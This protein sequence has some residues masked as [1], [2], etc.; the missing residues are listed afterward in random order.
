MTRSWTFARGGLACLL[1][2]LA[3]TCGGDNPS[4]PS[5]TP[6]GPPASSVT[7][8]TISGDASLTSPSETSQLT[9]TAALADGS[10][11]DVTALS[12]WN[13]SD[14]SI[15]TMSGTGLMTAVAL[16]TAVVEANYRGHTDLLDARVMPDG[17]FILSGS[18][19]EPVDLPIS[20]ALVEVIGGGTVGPRATV[21]EFGSYRFV[22]VSGT[23]SV[24]ASRSGYRSEEQSVTM[25]KDR[26]VN[27]ELQP[28]T[29]PAQMAGTYELTLTASSSCSA[30]LPR[31]ARSR[32][33][34][35]RIEQSGATVEVSLS[36]ADFVDTNGYYC[37][38]GPADHFTGVV[39]GNKAFFDLN[40]GGGFYSRDCFAVAERLSDTA[41]LG[42]DGSGEGT[43]SSSKISGT[44][45]GV[46]QIF[47]DSPSVC[48][49]KN[50]RFT[51][52][53]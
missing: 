46:F 16:G 52:S 15:I 4:S 28:T 41:N 39:R 34:T 22:G 30:L 51:F 19:T 44:L 2:G 45:D 53:R 50:H 5:P 32:T 26:T 27:L 8:L 10:T 23:V 42:I 48:A 25:S 12:A 1:V 43:I 35:A 21:A 49:A 11:Q 29:A 6:P 31:E 24:K 36:G 14:G 18:V 17:S 33:Y 3:V 38:P 9:A 20:D 13:S 37:R 47:P 40:A 7:G